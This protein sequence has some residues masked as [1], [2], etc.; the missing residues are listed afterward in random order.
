M[1]YAWCHCSECHKLAWCSLVDDGKW[2]CEECIKND[3][4]E[5]DV[6]GDD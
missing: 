1:T 3:M 4:A 2:L 6:K 5:D